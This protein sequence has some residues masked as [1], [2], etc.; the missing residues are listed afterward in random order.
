MNFSLETKNL[1]WALLAGSISLGGM[2]L[3]AVP[4]KMLTDSGANQAAVSA[5]SSESLSS[6]QLI[7]RG[8]QFF[9]MSCAHCHGDDAHGDEGP[10]LY[11]LPVSNAYIKVM[12]KRGVKGEMPTFAKKYNDDQVAALVAYLR[13]LR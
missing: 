10:D 11:N 12:I 4:I 7:E 6:P 9:A 3:A 5:P 1:K 8:S 2:L 13:S